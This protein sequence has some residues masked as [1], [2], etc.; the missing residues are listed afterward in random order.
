MTTPKSTTHGG[1]RENAGRKNVIP[2]EPT[3]I[4]TVRLSQS[5]YDWLLSQGNLSETLRHIISQ[6]MH[7][8]PA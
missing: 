1:Q 4:V 7:Q 2:D 6:Q 5:Q 3:K 8:K